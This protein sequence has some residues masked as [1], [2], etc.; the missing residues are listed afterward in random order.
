[1]LQNIF[2]EVD[3]TTISKIQVLN[4][5]NDSVKLYSNEGKNGVI[6]ITT[7]RPIEWVSAR[8]IL[9]QKANNI[10]GSYIKTLIKVGNAFFDAYEKLY[11]QKSLIKSISITNDTTQYYIDQQYNSVITISIKKKSGT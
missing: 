5:Q 2:F 4:P 8:Q 9:K 7:K 1:L 6:I 11:F 3:T 10:H